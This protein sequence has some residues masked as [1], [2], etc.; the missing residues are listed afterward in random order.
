MMQLTQLLS[1]IEIELPV[2][3]E[4]LMIRGIAYHSGKVRARGSLCVHYRI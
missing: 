4:A 2:H 3:A 1:A